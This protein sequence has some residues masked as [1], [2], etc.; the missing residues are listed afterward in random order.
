MLLTLPRIVFAGVSSGVGKTTV[1][2]AFIANLRTKGIRVQPFKVGPDYIDPSHLAFAAS[3][4]CFNL[5]TWMMPPGRMLDVFCMASDFVDSFDSSDSTEIA[6]IEGMMG[7][8]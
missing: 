7:L 1:T 2:T 4:P 5:D 6:V 3:Q 8:Y